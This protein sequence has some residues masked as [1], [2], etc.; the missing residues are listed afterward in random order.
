MIDDAALAKLEALRA[1]VASE[2]LILK[3]SFDIECEG[4]GDDL[5]AVCMDCRS[6]DQYE[7]SAIQVCGMEE[8]ARP[9]AELIV[10][11]WN[12]LPALI[13]AARG[14]EQLRGE[15]ERSRA[16]HAEAL[17]EL[18]T[19]SSAVFELARVRADRDA[20][21]Q[22]GITLAN[23]LRDIARERDEISAHF[24]ALKEVEGERMQAER[25]RDEA[26]A[27]LEQAQAEQA[28]CRGQMRKYAAEAKEAQA[29][30]LSQ[31]QA[32]DEAMRRA[33][34]A[35]RELAAIRSELLLP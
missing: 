22:Q 33:E 7:T 19:R 12:A 13:A 27:A 21:A 31:Q 16:M 35:R 29:A 8:F 32:T 4:C 11:A 15:L 25:E 14:L 5:G 9:T 2:P 18:D 1:E 24:D 28:F 6:T 34:E 26:R 30:L 3:S 20:L 23:G 10:A 17:K